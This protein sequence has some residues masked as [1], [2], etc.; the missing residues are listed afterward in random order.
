M[1]ISTK[2]R[3]MCAIQYLELSTVEQKLFTC[4]KKLLTEI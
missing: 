1:N 2:F 4:L 3:K